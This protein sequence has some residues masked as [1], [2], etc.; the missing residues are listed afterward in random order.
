MNE[1]TDVARP[2]QAVALADGTFRLLPTVDY[3]PEGE[4]WEF[5]PASVVGAEVQRFSSGEILVAVPLTVGAAD[6]AAVGEEVTKLNRGQRSKFLLNLANE[7]T[8]AARSAYSPACDEVQAPEDLRR[9]NEIMHRVLANLRDTLYGSNED[10]WAWALIAE[11][12][13]RLPQIPGA[14]R[15]ALVLTNKAQ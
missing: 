3:D 14:C 5:P 7:L 6:L 12:S 1:G 15:R 13:R 10:L 8:V 11:E 2:T 9:Y 4:I